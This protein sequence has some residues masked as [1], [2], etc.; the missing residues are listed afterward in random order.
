M[1]MI[2]VSKRLLWWAV[3]TLLF[4]GCTND[5]QQVNSEAVDKE[6]PW[7]GVSLR[8]VVAGDTPLAG[9]IDR[10]RGEWHAST[11][12]DLKVAE[13]KEEELLGEDPPQADVVIYPAY[14]LGVLAER[15]WLRPLNDKVLSS[16]DLAWAEIFEAD[17]TY[18]ANWGPVTYGFPFGSPTLVCFY[19]RD[20]L[21]KLDHEP[22]AT[23]SAYQELAAILAD[24]DKL[25]DAAPPGDAVWSGTMEPLAEGWAGLILLAR[26]AAYAKHR[27]HF[28]TLFDMESMDPLIAGA[29]FVRALQELVAA[30]PYILDDALD[31]SPQQVHEMFASGRCGMALTWSSGAFAGEGKASPTSPSGEE[32]DVGCVEL[33]GSPQAFNPKAE[34]WDARREGESPR[35]P[36]VGIAG[37][38][39]SVTTQS[40]HPDAAFQLLTW[41]SGTEWSRRVSTASGATTI[42]RRSQVDSSGE[43]VDPRLGAA[44]ALAYAETVERSLSSAD[45][46]GGPRIEGRGRYLAALDQ[47]VHE[48]VTGKAPSERALE[49]AADEWR[50]ITAELGLDRQRAA[51]RRSLGLR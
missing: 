11:G 26:A 15:G 47:A 44:G 3:P 1:R 17:K 42:F 22:P 2:A 37:R 40:D 21:D 7:K 50:K 33:P 48:A 8:L 5:A 41:L 4:A 32:L 24:R 14:D 51:Y 31:A 35:V 30:K 39:G 49:N 18:D 12:A 13:L 6:L 27:N 36:L 38:L 29:P 25:G 10:L 46:F 45:V 9:A 23:W 43:W 16:E 28:S 19:R 20:L 34:Q